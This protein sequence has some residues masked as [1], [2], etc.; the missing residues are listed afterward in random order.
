MNKEQ[1][2]QKV[3]VEVTWITSKQVVISAPAHLDQDKDEIGELLFFHDFDREVRD[4]ESW[5]F[6]SPVEITTGEGPITIL[7]VKWDEEELNTITVEEFNERI[8]G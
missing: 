8:H 4:L 5:S 2:T 7:A 6:R 3:V 1:E